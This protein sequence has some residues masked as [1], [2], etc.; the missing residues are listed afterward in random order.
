MTALAIKH[1]A[2]NLSQG[3]PDFDGPDFVKEAAFRAMKD[4]HNQYARMFGIPPLN[5]ALA[6]RW[7]D[8]TGHEVDPTTQITV[9]SGCTEGLA[10]ACLGLLNPGD[11]V[12]LFEPYYDSYRPCLAM[13]GA[14]PRFLPLAAPNFALDVDALRSLI[15]PG[16]T[17]AIM[18]NTPHN[19]TGKVFSREEL[20]AIADLCIQHDLIVISD[21]V[22]EHLV[23][24]GEHVRLATLPGM[25]NRTLTLSSLGKTFSLTGWKIGWAIGSVEMTRAIRAAHQFIVFSVPTPLQH[26]AVAAIEAPASFYEEFVTTYRQRRDLL[27][28]GLEDIGFIVHRPAGTYFVLCDHTPFG[29]VDDVSFCKHLVEHTGVAAIP[30][31]AFYE[32]PEHGRHLVRFAFC[33]TTETLEWAIDRMQGLSPR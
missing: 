26:G 30:P 1:E 19:P 11:E 17:R 6:S 20:Q 31:T 27:C 3:F 32:H 25:E 18:L 23:F 28:A 5:E 10:A 7:L 4:G 33:K 2:V 24:E 9:T 16:T 21:E 12:I 29:F 8:M 15:R 13:A 14:I 22:Y